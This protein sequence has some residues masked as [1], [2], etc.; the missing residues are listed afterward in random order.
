AD[1]DPALISAGGGVFPRA[2]KAI[3]LS[4]EIRT[5]LG[6]EEESLTPN[7]VLRAILRAPADLL[8][9]GG[10]GTYVKAREERHAEVGD[11]ANDGIRV[12]AAELRCRVVGEGGNLGFT[13]RARVEYALSGG[14]IFMDSI[15]NSAGVDC[16]DYEVNIKI[17]L[18][19]IVADGDLTEKQRNALLVEMT[20]DVAALVLRDNYEQA[21]ALSR[22]AAMAAS[23]L[24]VHE[25]YIRHLEQAGVLNREL[26]SLPSDDVLG[27]RK[28]AGGGLTMPEF[29][30]L[31]SHTKLALADELLASDLPE[32]PYFAGELERYFPAVLRERF[33]AQLAGHPLR[34]EIIAS[35]IANDLVNY[36][37]TTFA[38]RLGD[39]TG[40]GAD[41]I[42][43]AYTA[44]RETFGL[45]ALWAE[46]EALDGLVPSEPQIAMLLRS[47]VLLERATRWLL[48]KRRRPLDV[49]A[50][51][52]RFAPG[53]TTL[54]ATLPILLGP[55]DAEAAQEQAAELTAAGVPSQ[56]ADRVSQ[57]VALVPSLDLIEISAG[58][59]LDVVTVAE[60]YFTLGT[61]LELH[62]LRERIVA[63]PRDTRWEAMARAALRDDVYSEQAALTAAVFRAPA[64]DRPA[65]ELIESWLA[66]NQGAI[67]R[68]LHVLADIRAGGTFDL[69]RLSVAVREIRNLIHSSGS[70]EP[71]AVPTPSRASS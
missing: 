70:P 19:A 27:E 59:A 3:A 31:L 10:I 23:M 2:A 38:F 32:D 30:I 63:L 18:N 20:D 40:A 8:W 1:Y 9:N 45:P 25:R 50:A 67:E 24:E 15:D 42:A 60:V 52:G 64:G 68:S 36:A 62:W 16:S 5:A 41:E 46:I 65:R 66:E 33:A 69:A 39:E 44:A 56:L 13:Q 51:I 35:R 6:I 14:R 29:A 4:P 55:A 34:R 49:A 57:L 61:R 11:K 26:E 21:Q 7:E 58:S 17:L 37:G 22:S 71:A 43:R 28:A 12:D 48:R 53:A 47:R 54:A